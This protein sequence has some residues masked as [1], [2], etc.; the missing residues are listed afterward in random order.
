LAALQAFASARSPFY[1][2]FHDDLGRAALSE[3]PC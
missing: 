1:G 3:L 2:R